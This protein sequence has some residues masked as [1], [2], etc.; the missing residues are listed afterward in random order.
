MLLLILE[1][2]PTVVEERPKGKEKE[3]VAEKEKEQ[4]SQKDEEKAKEE[5][6]PPAREELEG[7]QKEKVKESE[8]PTLEA[9]RLLRVR[10]HH[11]RDLPP[12]DPLSSTVPDRKENAPGASSSRPAKAR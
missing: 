3:K 7:F 8:L 5:K 9:L 6:E 2:L 10:R 12:R 11:F 4:E 1:A